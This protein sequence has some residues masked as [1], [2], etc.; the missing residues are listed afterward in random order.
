MSGFRQYISIPTL[1]ATMLQIQ[2]PHKYVRYFNGILILFSFLWE[3]SRQA[4]VKV[5]RGMSNG[6]NLHG[7]QTFFGNVTNHVS[8]AG[9]FCFIIAFLS[10]LLRFILG[11]DRTGVARSGRVRSLCVHIQWQMA[12]HT[13][14]IL[15][16]FTW[17]N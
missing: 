13:V 3:F 8:K 4:F 11:M 6:S 12:G 9:I 16:L 10:P 7:G 2:K 14:S 1:I 5:C 17:R 15:S